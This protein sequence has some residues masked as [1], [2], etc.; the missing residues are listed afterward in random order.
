M[1]GE[2]TDLEKVVRRR[3]L[4]PFQH[5][6]R[7]IVVSLEPGNILVMRLDGTRK[8]YRAPLSAVFISLCQWE[9]DAKRR[10]KGQKEKSSRVRRWCS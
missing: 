9:S 8:T 5:Y 1:I 6:K 3:G 2:L 10:E 4:V 7:R